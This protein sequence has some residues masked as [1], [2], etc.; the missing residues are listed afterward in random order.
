MGKRTLVGLLVALAVLAA[1]L[2][3]GIGVYEKQEISA[4]E[5]I[6]QPTPEK[7]LIFLDD[8]VATVNEGQDLSFKIKVD[9][10]AWQ[11]S[12]KSRTRID[13]EKLK[14]A[15]LDLGKSKSLAILAYLA[16][17]QRN[18]K[19]ILKGPNYQAS[20]TQIAKTNNIQ[21]MAVTVQAKVPSGIVLDKN[22]LIST[23]FL[24]EVNWVCRRKLENFFTKKC[25][26]RWEKIA[27]AKDVDLID[28]TKSLADVKIVSFSN[29]EDLLAPD[30]AGRKQTTFS[31][32]YQNAGKGV[33]SNVKLKLR[34]PEKTFDLKLDT[35]S[36]ASLVKETIEGQV[37]DVL[38]WNLGNLEPM[39]AGAYEVKATA[40]KQSQ[41][42]VMVVPQV[43]ISADSNDPGL[44]NNKAE[45]P[46]VIV[47][48]TDVL[49]L[50]P[51]STPR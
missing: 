10:L 26:W 19:W 37:Y 3:F 25:E 2:Y 50:T 42:V 18:G 12:L 14:Q 32:S 43:E 27:E 38:V 28:Y 4:D 8:G 47:S 51:Q 16:S 1:S 30:L 15:V 39:A 7:S 45:T 40:L 48:S 35:N 29:S 44:S 17:G 33:A 13:Q 23:A 46:L 36:G 20:L 34:V 22:E 41:P 11:A 21:D 6:A 9:F 49:K 31:V 5:A 24:M